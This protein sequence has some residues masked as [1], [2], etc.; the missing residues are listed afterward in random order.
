M[1]F[2]VGNERIYQIRSLQN[3]SL[4]GAT[5]NEQPDARLS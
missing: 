2:S 1:S 4:T 5:T 3:A